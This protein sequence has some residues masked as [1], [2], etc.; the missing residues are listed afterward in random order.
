[1]HKLHTHKYSIERNGFECSAYVNALCYEKLA[2]NIFLIRIL[3]HIKKYL[4]ILM[5]YTANI[6]YSMNLHNFLTYK[7][8]V[9]CRSVSE[10]VSINIIPLVCIRNVWYTYHSTLVSVNLNV[11]LGNELWWVFK[12]F[13]AFSYSHRC[14]T[15]CI[16]R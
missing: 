3:I 5:V 9:S 11:I 4:E 1:M 12:I 2:Q 10:C 15:V 13:Q 6:E 14:C 7:R 16:S 8:K